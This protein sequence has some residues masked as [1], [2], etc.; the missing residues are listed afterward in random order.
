MSRLRTMNRRRIRA[1]RR[2]GRSEELL[3]LFKA[4]MGRA[5]MER[6]ADRLLADAKALEEREGSDEQARF[7]ARVMRQIAF[8]RKFDAA[9]TMAALLS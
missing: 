9:T 7:R 8:Q 3:T 6:S 1:A 2:R 4:A 5:L